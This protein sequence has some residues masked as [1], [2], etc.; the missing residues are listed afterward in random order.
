MVSNIWE[1]GNGSRASNGGGGGGVGGVGGAGGSTSRPRQPPTAPRPRPSWDDADSHDDEALVR[2]EAP[3]GDTRLTVSPKIRPKAPPSEGREFRSV[4]MAVVRHSSFSTI[5][6]ME[7]RWNGEAQLIPAAG[8]AEPEVR[9]ST[10]FLD[11][12]AANQRWRQ[13]QAMTSKDGISTKQTLLLTPVS[14]GVLAAE[15]ED[16]E[17]LDMKVEERG[18]DVVLLTATSRE[19]GKI[20]VVETITLIDDLRRVRSVQRFDGSGA[21]TA[22]Y[23]MKE[24]RVIDSVSGALEVPNFRL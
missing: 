8:G 6:R 2:R 10:V 17:H 11:F 13:Q 20:V 7:G 5:H 9:V 23:L 4:Y 3:P 15:S 18:L 1:G 12:D 19:T 14:D 16:L 21:F 22:M 24:Q